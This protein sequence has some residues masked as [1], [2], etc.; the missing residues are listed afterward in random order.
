[1]SG[2]KA[3]RKLK[4]ALNEFASRFKDPS[5]PSNKLS[6]YNRG[7]RGAMSTCVT[8]LANEKYREETKRTTVVQLFT[9]RE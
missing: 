5:L 6:D 7:Y 3:I 8:I 2:E 1:M 9:Q 4:E